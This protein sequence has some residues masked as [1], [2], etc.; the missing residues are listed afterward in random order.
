MTSIKLTQGDDSNA[1]GEQI[2]ISLKSNIDLTGYSALF[3]LGEFRQEFDDISS[4][5]LPII[6]PAEESRKL[7][8]GPLAGRLKIF[9]PDGLQKTV[10]R[11]IMFKV[12]PGDPENG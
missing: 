8:P 4:K 2:V 7:P 9:D 6:I 10:I 3:Q 5:E 11:N 12:E 1:L